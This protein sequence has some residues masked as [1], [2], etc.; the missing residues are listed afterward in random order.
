M[1]SDWKN[2]LPELPRL[3]G[4]QTCRKFS[5]GD[6]AGKR[7]RDVVRELVTGDRDTTEA[8]QVVFLMTVVWK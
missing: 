2:E 8:R 3:P 6:D 7:V 4:L 1:G 5:H